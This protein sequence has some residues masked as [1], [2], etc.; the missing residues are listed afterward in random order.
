MLVYVLRFV[1]ICNWLKSREISR[2][3]PIRW[4]CFCFRLHYCT[5]RSSFLQV[6]FA[7]APRREWSYPEEFLRS[8]TRSLFDAYHYVLRRIP[9]WTRDMSQQNSFVWFYNN[10]TSFVRKVQGKAGEITRANFI[11]YRLLLR[12]YIIPPIFFL[13]FPFDRH[14]ALPLAEIGTSVAFRHRASIPVHRSG[15][16]G[17]GLNADCS[18]TSR[19]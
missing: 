1:A 8:V 4:P 14:S 13:V 19:Y 2:T 17:D 3:M 11:S 7:V 5:N 16:R 9:A 6:S 10:K 12:V 18:G 15:K